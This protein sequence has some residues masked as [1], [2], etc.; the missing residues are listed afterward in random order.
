M[1]M[2]MDSWHCGDM[3]FSLVV[4]VISCQFTFTTQIGTGTVSAK[5][6]VLAVG[7]GV[8]EFLEV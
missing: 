4:P 2:D 8:S 7:A 5:I 3:D 6:L 1:D